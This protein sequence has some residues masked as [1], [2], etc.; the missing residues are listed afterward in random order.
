ME[1]SAQQINP[2]PLPGC[3]YVKFRG[4]KVKYTQN[5]IT[6][7]GKTIRFPTSQVV[8]GAS[9]YL[10]TPL[11]SIFATPDMRSFELLGMGDIVGVVNSS[12]VVRN[13]SSYWVYNNGIRVS[14]VFYLDDDKIC[15]NHTKH[16]HEICTSATVYE[17]FLVVTHG[18]GAIF[19]D[20]LGSNDVKC[21][22]AGPVTKYYRINSR[23]IGFFIFEYVKNKAVHKALFY[24]SELICSDVS[25]NMNG[26]VPVIRHRGNKCPSQVPV[27]QV[28]DCVSALYAENQ[29]GCVGDHSTSRSQHCE[30]AED[31]PSMTFEL[32]DLQ[33]SAFEVSPVSTRVAFLRAVFSGQPFN[34]VSEA[35]DRLLHTSKVITE[36]ISE[37]HGRILESPLFYESPEIAAVK[38]MPKFRFRGKP[39]ERELE[40]INRQYQRLFR[41]DCEITKSKNLSYKIIKMEKS[42]FKNLCADSLFSGMIRYNRDFIR[43]INAYYEDPRIEEILSILLETATTI[44]P[45]LSD[46]GNCRQSAFLLRYTCGIGAFVINHRRLYYDSIYKPQ[47]K[48]NSISFDDRLPKDI[49]FLTSADLFSYYKKPSFPGI[50][51]QLGHAFGQ[52]LVYGL[53]RDALEEY[54]KLAATSDD[55]TLKLVYLVVA[56][57]PAHTDL[58]KNHSINTLFKSALE[59]G[60]LDIRKAAMCGLA[61]YNLGS[62]DRN[63]LAL[64][65]GEIERFGPVKSERNIAFYDAE[66]RMLAAICTALCA[67]HPVLWKLNDSF[68]ELV[69]CGLTSVGSGISHD[70]L[71]RS[72][73]YRPEE[74]FYSALLQM[75]SD[76]RVEP[77]E[78]LAGLDRVDLRGSVNDTYRLAAK[79][80]YISLYYLN[81]DRKCDEDVYRKVYEFALRLEDDVASGR[82]IQLLF[83]FTLASMAIMKSGTCDIELCRIIRRVILKT[84]DTKYMKDITLFDHRAKDMISLRGYD[85]ESVQVYKLCL[86]LTCLNFGISRLR[87]TAVKQL[88]VAFFITNS[89]A[90]EFNFVD[91]LRM[92]IVKYFDDDQSAIEDL[93]QVAKRLALKLKRKACMKMFESEF[94]QL[95]EIDKKFVI[96]VLSDYYENYHSKCHSDSVFDLKMLAR[97]VSITK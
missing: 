84:K 11:N 75:T 95:G 70:M 5:I 86:G 19:I 67:E 61:I 40:F 34:I 29:S 59:V 14:L 88:I 17:K 12:L 63:V 8:V 90:L 47:I 44:Q 38:R 24:Q 66:Y 41:Y 51:E 15:Y 39:T 1:N 91:V 48:V 78:L 72:D 94:D 69:V 76:F 36:L 20:F 46:V 80:F 83:N 28:S 43:L 4:K 49:S 87:R 71:D 68:C 22:F 13:G 18:S 9:L 32:T 53:P 6:Y 16:A 58:G 65:Q 64:L 55:P 2:T 27:G 25:V 31:H 82:P 93:K 81:L 42:Y 33:H 62:H 60:T 85:M 57:Y 56:T 77:R 26:P 97:L 23:K 37:K 30:L 74:I 45:D 92:Q 73:D 89:V 96:D 52:G 21:R 50:H 3:R 54:L 35:F 10:Q 7:N 79:V